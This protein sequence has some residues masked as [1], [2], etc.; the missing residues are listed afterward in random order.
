MGLARSRAVTLGGE[1]ADVI[2]REVTPTEAA[3]PPS[4]ATRDRG[5]FMTARPPTTY[6]LPPRTPLASSTRNWAGG[7]GARHRWPGGDAYP[8]HD[9]GAELATTSR[10]AMAAPF[11]VAPST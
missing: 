10:A 6:G 3:V 2:V 8:A 7:P 9:K 5:R 1:T 11:K 4:G